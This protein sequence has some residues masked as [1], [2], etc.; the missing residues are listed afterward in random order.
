MCLSTAEGS[1]ELLDVEGYVEGA[2]GTPETRLSCEHEVNLE[3]EEAQSGSKPELEAAHEPSMDSSHKPDVVDS[4]NAPEVGPELDSESETSG[5]EPAIQRAGQAPEDSL[6]S[7]TAAYDE[8]S[9]E[10]TYTAL[11]LDQDK[12]EGGM[13]LDQAAISKLQGVRPSLIY[14]N[15]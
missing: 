4:S 15:N 12:L 6:E 10:Q 1:S 9:Q 8:H 7:S 3:L 14:L 5:G 13:E 11:E 2:E